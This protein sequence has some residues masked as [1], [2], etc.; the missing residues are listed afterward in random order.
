MSY[1]FHTVLCKLQKFFLTL[2]WKNFVKAMVLLN[3]WFDEFFSSERFSFSHICAIVRKLLKFQFFSKRSVKSNFSL[4]SFKSNL[5]SRNILQMWMIV[6][7]PQEF[8]INFTE[9]LAIAEF[10]SFFIIWQK[11]REIDFNTCIK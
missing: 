11:F 8:H 7:F 6:N 1:F 9:K 5:I 10:D 3:N 4:I 2:F